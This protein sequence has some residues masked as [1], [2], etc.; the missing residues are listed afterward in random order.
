MTSLYILGIYSNPKNR[1]IYKCHRSEAKLVLVWGTKAYYFKKDIIR[2]PKIIIGKIN[3]IQ[4]NNKQK[5]N[6]IDKARLRKKNWTK[7]MK[8]LIILPCQS[9]CPNIGTNKFLSHKI[10]ASVLLPSKKNWPH[11]L[12]ECK[13]PPVYHHSGK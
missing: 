4:N 13:I 5:T 3:Q 2:P 10:G 12:A 6:Q 7:R 8:K 11:H 1:W 9:Y